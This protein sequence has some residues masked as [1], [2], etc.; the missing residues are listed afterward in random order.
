MSPY[1]EFVAELKPYKEGSFGDTPVGWGCGYVT[2]P[3]GSYAYRIYDLYE[4]EEIGGLSWLNTLHTEEFTLCQEDAKGNL[5]IGFDTAHSW[6]TPENS[7]FAIV[8]AKTQEIMRTVLNIS[9]A[10][11]DKHIKALIATHTAKINELLLL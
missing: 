10:E 4:R 5:L 2:I 3:R 11:Y 7:S 8:E 9:R 6:C 1:G